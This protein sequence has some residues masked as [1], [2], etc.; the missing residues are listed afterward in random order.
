M[1]KALCIPFCCPL[2]GA[3]DQYQ[4]TVDSAPDWNA[5]LDPAC[6]PNRLADAPAVKRSKFTVNLAAAGNKR[7]D[8][9]GDELPSLSNDGR[10]A[11]EKKGVT[12]S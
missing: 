1:G 5:I 11:I 9:M 10:I 2:T 12:S 3:I 6:D 4:S 8:I 7:V